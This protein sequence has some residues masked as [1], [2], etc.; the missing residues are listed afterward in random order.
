MHRYN[1]MQN[2]CHDGGVHTLLK[3]DRGG[4]IDVP[5]DYVD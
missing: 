2:K 1:T 5:C 4:M 3:E